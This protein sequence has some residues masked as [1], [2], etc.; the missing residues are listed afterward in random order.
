MAL[1]ICNARVVRGSH[2]ILDNV[3]LRVEAGEVVVLLGPN[4][5][6][7]STLL[8]AVAGDFSLDRGTLQLNGVPLSSM[9]ARVRA[10]S[11]AF[12][13]QRTHVPLPLAVHEVIGFGVSAGISPTDRVRRG[14]RDRRVA[15]LSRRLQ[16][17][18]LIDRDITTLSGGEAQRVHLARVLAQVWREEPDAPRLLLLDEPT[19]A[20]DPGQAAALAAELR[21]LAGE[22]RLAVLAV[23]HDLSLASR[24]ADH[25]AVLNA[26]RIIAAGPPAV[27][28]SSQV[29]SEVF[30]PG[31]AVSADQRDA[32]PVV[33]PD[34]RAAERDAATHHGSRLE[35]SARST[36]SR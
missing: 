27:C 7:K 16:I 33:L 30:G 11:L 19:S 10:R 13:R 26:G 24:L 1:T 15:M 21:T 17:G 28:L 9:R 23:V 18:H 31:L 2:T 12:L 22:Q 36:I 6:G 29:V 8:N 5:A 3:S 20:L 4:G 32:L 25:L 35:R 14:E 34:F